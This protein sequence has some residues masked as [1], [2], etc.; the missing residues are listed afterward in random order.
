MFLF[1]ISKLF[2]IRKKNSSFLFI[3]EYKLYI[4]SNTVNHVCLFQINLI[5]FTF[6]EKNNKNY[7]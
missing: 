7:G 1:K 6:L 3:L 2:E 4:Y 5:K